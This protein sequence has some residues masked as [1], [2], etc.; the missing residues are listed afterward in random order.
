MPLLCAYG[1]RRVFS[2]VMWLIMLDPLTGEIKKRKKI[3][4]FFS[5]YRIILRNGASE[6]T[7]FIVRISISALTY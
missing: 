3:G 4:F 7:M 5:L 2:L 1:I 6:Y